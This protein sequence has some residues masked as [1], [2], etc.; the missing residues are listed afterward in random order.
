MPPLI[1]IVVMSWSVTWGHNCLTS[2]KKVRLQNCDRPYR[3]EPFLNAI[4]ELS[5]YYDKTN[6]STKLIKVIN[7][8]MGV[9]N[10]VTG[11]TILRYELLPIE[12]RTF[13]VLFNAYSTNGMH[14]NTVKEVDKSG[15]SLG[16]YVRTIQPIFVR[17]VMSLPL[18]S[19]TCREDSNNNN[20]SRWHQPL[21]FFLNNYLGNEQREVLATTEVG[22]NMHLLASYY[23]FGSVS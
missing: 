18:T 22:K 11:E 16:E 23:G 21:L 19:P 8:T 9:T 7:S 20:N 5:S 12:S 1:T 10:S 14:V 3:L 17:T 2:V 6:D 13:N 15:G 4:S